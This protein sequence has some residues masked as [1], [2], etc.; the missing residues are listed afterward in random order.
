MKQ[1]YAPRAVP[2]AVPTA[3]LRVALTAVT[4]ALFAVALYMVFIFVPDISGLRA[5]R[6]FYFHVPVDWVAFLAYFVVFICSIVYLRK[7]D[8][9]WDLVAVSAAELGV[10]FN[11]LMLVT[12]SIWARPNWGTW[13]NW[14]PRLTT[15][16][17]LWVVYVGYL[18]VRSYASG[19]EQAAR[20]SAVIG[21]VGFVDVPIVYLSTM[22]WQ[23]QHPGH[24]VFETGGLA[25]SMLA[26]LMVSLAAFTCLFALLLVERVS[27]RKMEA[28][29]RAMKENV[30]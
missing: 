10:L 19:R 12:G 16:L 17:V 6:I 2:K 8:S 18:L 15:A 28:E 5:D 26:A 11:T 13:W 20:F 27:L 4:A 30:E 9:A 24:L 21:I 25:P 14:E 3:V 7:R 29:L 23:L 1:G 22:W